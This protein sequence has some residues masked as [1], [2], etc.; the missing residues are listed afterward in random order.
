M[1]IRVGA[2]KT[3]SVGMTSKSSYY[4]LK[5]LDSIWIC[6]PRSFNSCGIGETRSGL[7]FQPLR[8]VKSL[9]VLENS[10]LTTTGCN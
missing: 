10:C 8:S 7:A 6:S 1:L 4:M 2:S 9:P 5:R 3:E